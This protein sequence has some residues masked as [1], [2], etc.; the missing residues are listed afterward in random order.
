MPRKPLEAYRGFPLCST[1]WG[2]HPPEEPER[3]D[4]PSGW[5]RRPDHR[6]KTDS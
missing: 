6:E 4:P 1:V 3:L 5:P 2:G